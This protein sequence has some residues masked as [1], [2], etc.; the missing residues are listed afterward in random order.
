MNVNFN[1]IHTVY[2]LGAGGIGMSALAR[3]FKL[4]GKE[5]YGYDLH[6]TPLTEQL[7][8]EG[9]HIHYEENPS[10]IPAETGLVIYTPA[11]PDDNKEM[12]ALKKSNIPML[13][14]AEVLG[15]LSEGYNTIAV[16]GTHGKTSITAMTSHLLAS[17]G[18]SVIAFIGGIALNFNSNFVHYPG[19]KVMVVEADEYD[20]SMLRLRPYHALI[21]SVSADHLDIYKDIDDLRN[22]FVQFANQTDSQGA[23]I[24]HENV[25]LHGLK[26]KYILKYGI[27]SGSEG[28]ASD[29]RVVNG[30]FTFA[31]HLPDS[32]PMTVTMEVPGMH[33]VQNAVGAA[34]LA[35]RWGLNPEQIK[36]GLESFKGVER[37]FNFRI[38]TGSCIYID[39]YAHHPEEIEATLGAARMLFPDKKMTVVFQPHLYSRTRDFADAFG[40]A[41]S[42]ADNIILLPIYPAREK[43]I[44]GITSEFLLQKIEKPEKQ[45]LEKEALYALLKETKPE[46][47]LTLGAGDIGMMTDKIEETLIK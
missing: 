23:V 3:Y 4:E 9:I 37:R 29:I 35:Y 30:K 15:L 19:A 41:L 11:I 1:D 43:P 38:R 28:Y 22:T 32:E 24:L 14:R 21:S 7:E 40:K 2:F 12:I 46:L 17:T 20:R 10:L 33:Y 8:S 25:G 36:N 39:D 27:K 13:K 47:L 31:L 18:V 42:K 44:P 6:R 16:A 34:M 45:L 5:V 26:N